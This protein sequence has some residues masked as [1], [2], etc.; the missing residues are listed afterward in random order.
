MIEKLDHKN[1]VISEKIRFIFQNS[2]AIEAKLLNAIDFPPLKR[3][4]V[5]FLN[6]ETAFYGY[7]KNNEI[8]AIIEIE[9]NESSTEI[10]SLVVDPKFFRQGLAKNLINFVIKSFNSEIF[11]VE[12]GLDNIPAVQLYEQFNFKEIK[13]WETDYGVKKIRYEK[14]KN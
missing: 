8:S 4:L 7:M 9:N 13:Q 2:Y 10:H 14:V 6:S 1:I 3:T 5:E 11:Y 12:T